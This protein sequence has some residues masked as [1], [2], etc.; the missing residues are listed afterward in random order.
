MKKYQKHPNLVPMVYLNIFD[1]EG[2]VPHHDVPYILK[3]ADCA[4][5]TGNESEAISAKYTSPLKMFEYMASGCPI[6][7][8]DLPSFREV[9]NNE[10]SFLVEPGNAKTL[11]EKI[12]WVFDDKNKESVK[13][14]AAKALE[15][16]RNYTWQ[17]RVHGIL[18][19]IEGTKNSLGET[20]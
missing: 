16:V 13:R 19:F 6:V 11:A 10:N 1:I 9:L 15:D 3:A 8:Q 14:I 17:Q 12:A 20:Y 5:L 18:G 2:R 4:I 7:A